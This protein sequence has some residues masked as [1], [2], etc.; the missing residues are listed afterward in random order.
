MEPTHEGGTDVFFK[1]D[2]ERAAAQA[3]KARKDAGEVGASAASGDGYSNSTVRRS[4]PRLGST[5]STST[6]LKMSDQVSSSAIRTRAP[7]AAAS[8]HRYSPSSRPSTVATAPRNPRRAA[9]RRIR[10][11]L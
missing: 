8:A 2:A 11:R 7:A 3:A 4:C 1:T 10:A 6:L 5:C 9:R